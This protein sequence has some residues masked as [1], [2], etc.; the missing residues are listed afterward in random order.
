MHQQ[1]KVATQLRFTL[2]SRRH[3]QRQSIAKCLLELARA[4]FQDFQMSLGDSQHRLGIGDS[5][6]KLLSMK[7][8]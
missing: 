2:L 3:R 8:L 1:V 6:S 5:E 4:S 7:R